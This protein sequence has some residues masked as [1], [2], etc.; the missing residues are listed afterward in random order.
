MPA[1]P[2]DVLAS[3]SPGESSSQVRARVVSARERQR[4]RY[5]GEG[6]RT[7]AELTPALIGR[8]CVLDD[9]GVRLLSIA[10]ARMALSARGYDR[11]RKV[12]RTIADLA[13]AD[14]VDAGHVAEALQFRLQ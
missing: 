11:V 1:L 8:H 14:T 12:A 4:C 9:A 6:L 2:P 13:G 10:A 3:G 7:N 5:S